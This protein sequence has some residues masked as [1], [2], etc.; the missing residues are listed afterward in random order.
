MLGVEDMLPMRLSSVAAL[1][2]LSCTV[3]AQ[4]AMEIWKLPPITFA[5]TPTVRVEQPIA[6]QRAEVTVTNF[7]PQALDTP[8]AELFEPEKQYLYW[9]SVSDLKPATQV[10]VLDVRGKWVLAER[11]PCSGGTTVVMWFNASE[12]AGGWSPG[13]CK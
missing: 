3:S 10:K 1:T 4:Q 8:P 5:G 11:T 7:P 12:Q 2:V 9:S 6:I 13:K